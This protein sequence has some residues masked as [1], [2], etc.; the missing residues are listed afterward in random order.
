MSAQGWYVL[1]HQRNR[2][3]NC[4]PL[5]QSYNFCAVERLISNHVASQH[6]RVPHFLPNCWAG[7]TSPKSGKRQF[8]SYTDYT[9][10]CVHSTAPPTTDILRP[11]RT[12]YRPRKV[13]ANA[14]PRE[15]SGM[16]SHIGIWI[17]S[18]SVRS[19]HLSACLA[20]ILG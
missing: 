8:N 11:K 6:R 18:L 14:A 9:S 13:V 1:S 17:C 10:D 20:P 16:P 19:D 12:A 3:F 7:C 2:M 4:L 5:G 15:S